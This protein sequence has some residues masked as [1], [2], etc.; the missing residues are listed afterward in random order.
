MSGSTAYFSPA[1]HRLKFW[2]GSSC[3]KRFTRYNGKQV[4]RHGRPEQLVWKDTCLQSMEAHTHRPGISR[5]LIGHQVSIAAC[6]VRDFEMIMG[7]DEAESLNRK[8][9]LQQRWRVVA[10]RLHS[11]PYAPSVC[12]LKGIGLWFVYHPWLGVSSVSMLHFW[13]NQK[14]LLSCCHHTTVGASHIRVQ[15]PGCSYLDEW[16]PKTHDFILT[17][18][19]EANNDGCLAQSSPPQSE[20]EQGHLLWQ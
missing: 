7:W 8:L 11:L 4:N 9:P 19:L 10:K 3:S 12:P 13:D 15:H 17:R 5:W 18:F 6:W 2:S 20:R 16:A 14:Q 1:L